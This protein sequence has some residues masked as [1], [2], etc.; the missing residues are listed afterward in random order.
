MTLFGGR[1][2]QLR[3]MIARTDPEA[4]TPI[5]ALRI[6]AELKKYITSSTEQE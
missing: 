2:E 4:T 6:L 3:G 1:D 5:E